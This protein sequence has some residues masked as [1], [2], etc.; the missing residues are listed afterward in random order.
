MLLDPFPIL[1]DG[2]DTSFGLE[3][4]TGFFEDMFPKGITLHYTASHSA[5]NA[6]KYLR[7]TNKRYHLLIDPSGITYQTMYF[8]QTV[9][10]AGSAY[11]N[12]LSPNANH[13]SVAIVSWGK[14]TMNMGEYFTWVKTPIRTEEVRVIKDKDRILSFWHKATK[15]QI[16]ALISFCV[17]AA[18]YGIDP[19]NICGHDECCIPR[20]RKEDPGHILPFTMEELRDIIKKN[21]MLL[22]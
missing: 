20:G 1:Y 5:E 22:S 17:F 8:N 11:W 14:L 21:Q 18:K 15:E 7:T 19:D 6:I 16:N 10:H 9:N 2:A 3:M 12:S 4:G 13:I